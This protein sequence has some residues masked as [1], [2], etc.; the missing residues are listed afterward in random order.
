M[1]T[2]TGAGAALLYVALAALAA[3]SLVQGNKRH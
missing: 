3:I 2:A 1:F